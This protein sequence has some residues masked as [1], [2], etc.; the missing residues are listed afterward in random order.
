M[1]I[2]CVNNNGTAYLRVTEV[3]KDETTTPHTTRR[4]VIRNIGPLSRYDDGQPDYLARLRQSMR[5]GCPIIE[6]LGDLLVGKPARK[7]VRVEFDLDSEAD[8]TC[9]PKNIGHFLLD[10]MYDALGVNEVLTLAKSRS[11][12]EYDLNGVAR[13]LVFG[14]ALWPDSK[15]STFGQRDR[16]QFGVAATA[17]LQDVYRALDRL[18]AASVA[19][20]KRM[21]R[22]IAETVGRDTDVCYYDVTNFYFEI[23]ENDEDSAAADGGPAREGLRKRGPSK[24]KG[25]E[26]IVQMGLFIDRNGIPIAFQTFPG[27]HVDQTTLRPAMKNTFD[28]MKFGRVIIVADGGLNSGKNI[29]HILHGGNGYIV[30]KSVKKAAKATKQWILDEDG[31]E[32]NEQRTFKVKSVT[33]K[34]VITLEDKSKMVI[35]EKLVS[36]WSKKHYDR[37]MRDNGKFIEYLRSVIANP[38][39]LKD[40]PRK[41]ERFLQKKELDRETLEVVDTK[42]HLSI[43]MDAVQDYI[44]LLGYY[45]LM[46]SETQR[47][48]REIIDK[49]HGLS[50]IEDSFRITKSDLEGR[51]V[52]VSNPGRI[53][54]HFLVCF[55]AL[56]IIRLIQHRVLTHLGIGTKNE[57]GWEAGITAERIQEALASYQADALP[58]GYY[59]VTAPND[60]MKLILESFGVQA[61]PRLPT[62]TDLRKLKRAFDKAG[63]I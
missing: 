33:R 46:T 49:Y 11:K 61:C 36:Y 4:R 59:R 47:P 21:N 41:A 15:L 50:R 30:S 39:K 9:D 51:P 35:D 38:D 53:N 1:F 31:Y 52:Y 8:C 55:I 7:T 29:G 16:Y 48:D 63:L 18:N 10:G 2:E 13:L 17:G 12:L 37:E 24:K 42:T 5:D 27:N 54:A 3:R 26:P 23:H 56:T 25:P 6:S 43:D 44:D 45:T 58:G 32:W 14:R 57:F 22:R 62:A 34:R 20:Q 19:V 28:K 40:K 60:D